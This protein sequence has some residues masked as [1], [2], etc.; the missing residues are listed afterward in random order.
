MPSSRVKFE[1][2][3]DPDKKYDE[4]TREVNALRPSLPAEIARLEIRK[5]SP[6]LVNIV[7]F[8]LVSDTAPYRELED[9]A[10]DLKDALKTVEGVRT[11][12]TWAFPS[13]ELRVEVDLRRMA[14][15]MITPGRADRGAAEREQQRAGRRARSRAAQLHA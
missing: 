6:A 13:R 10:R 11:A 2:F 8:A 4:V 9:L 7:Q 14:E 12:E 15:L 1:A 3:T 5:V